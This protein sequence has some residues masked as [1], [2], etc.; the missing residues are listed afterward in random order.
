MRSSS[1]I[2][3]QFTLEDT[4]NWGD[5]DLAQP[6]AMNEESLD[7]QD[8]DAMRALGHRMVDDMMA[9][10]QTVRERPVWQ[11]VPDDVRARMQ[12]PLPLASEPPEEIYHD[13]LRDVLPFGMGN[14]HPRFWGW[15]MGNGTVL[16]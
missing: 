6:E 1:R 8:W 5:K 16:G 10:L 11:P 7:P 12:E 13:F 9:Y 14:P 2:N 3:F 4:E 15:V